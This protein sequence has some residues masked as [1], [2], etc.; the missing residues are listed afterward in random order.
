M[1]D[2]FEV[3]FGSIVGT[4]HVG[5]GNLLVGR[6]NQDAGFTS[7]TDQY[8]LLL[9]TDGCGSGGASEV[10]AQLGVRLVAAAISRNYSL[11]LQA[12]KCMDANLEK[13]FWTRVEDETLEYL[14]AL[15]SGFS[16]G[17]SNTV[18]EY[19]LFTVVGALIG[20]E[21]TSLF[22]VGDGV[23]ALNGDVA[24]LGP[25]D[26]N[27]PPYLGYAITGSS[28]TD[29]DPELLDFQMHAVLPTSEVQTLLVGTDGVADFMVK[30]YWKL[31]GQGKSLGSLAQFWEEDKYFRNPDA[32]RRALSLANR[33]YV[34]SR[35]REG[36]NTLVEYG[37]LP[38]D[39]T[40]AVARRRKDNEHETDF[41]G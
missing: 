21:L 3:A 17:I 23:F 28:I 10:G 22:S 40:I 37:L 11:L 1:K 5:R 13:Q 31:P 30:E 41:S 38:D 9:V 19:F 29:E 6:N 27:F 24:Q 20:Q 4:D 15:A 36:Q 12:Q 25:Y 16:S 26:G 18:T 33:T 7:Q 39:T 8:S 34:H 2:V 32:L 35:T 14:R